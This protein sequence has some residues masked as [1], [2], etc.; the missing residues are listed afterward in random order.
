MWQISYPLQLQSDETKDLTKKREAAR[1]MIKSATGNQKKIWKLLS[2]LLYCASQG[3][4]Y[5][6]Y[7]VLQAFLKHCLY[8]AAPNPWSKY[9]IGKIR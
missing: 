3:N 1:S 8:C 5:A 4:Y 9:T 7:N 2:L 6:K